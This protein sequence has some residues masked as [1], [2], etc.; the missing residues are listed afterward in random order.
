MRRE[1]IQEREYFDTDKKDMIGWKSNDRC[2]HCGKLKYFHYGATVD[3]FIPL[4]Q[5]GSNRTYNLIM[6][7]EDCNKEKGNKIMDLSYIRYLK[8]KYMK[9]LAAYY[10]SYIR[11]FEYI[12]RN[13]IFACDYYKVLLLSPKY[14]QMHKRNK[15]LKPF[16]KELIL[17]SASMDDFQRISDYYDDYLT[18]T[19]DNY[20]PSDKAFSTNKSHSREAVEMNIAFWMNFGAIYYLEDASGEITTMTVFLMRPARGNEL[21][22]NYPY[23]L[24]MY[25]FSKYSTDNALQTVTNMCIE[26]PR[27]L[28]SEQNLP[29]IPVKITMLPEDRLSQMVMLTLSGGDRGLIYMDPLNEMFLSMMICITRPE[30]QDIY[31]LPEKEL[32]KNKEFF[33]NFENSLNSRKCVEYL[34]EYASSDIDWM[35]YDIVTPEYIRDNGIFIDDAHKKKNDELLELMNDI[36]ESTKKRAA[37][38]LIEQAKESYRQAETKET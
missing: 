38:K 28:I 3:H 22:I 24:N 34:K 5:G 18:R 1:K 35:L 16:G 27:F 8:P 10:D 14:Q 33:K 32:A 19:I 29:E 9:E 7:C 36:E 11:S 31:T 37:G 12:T 21:D 30:Y 20:K 15:K 2:C 26:L 17:K 4:S 13:K 23:I 6:L 25:I